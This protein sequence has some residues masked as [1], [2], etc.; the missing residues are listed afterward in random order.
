MLLSNRC[1]GR[2]RLGLS[3]YGWGGYHSGRDGVLST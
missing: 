2:E 3:A 1:L